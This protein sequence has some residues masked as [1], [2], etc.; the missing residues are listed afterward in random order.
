MFQKKQL[1]V[2]DWFGFHF[3]MI[4]PLVNI[5]IYLILLFTPQ[6]NKTLRNYL[7]YQVLAVFFWIGLFIM[8]I[9][10][11]PNLIDMLRAFSEN[12]PG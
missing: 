12:Y 3:L 10:L 4:I 5:I 9:L 8:L 2:L 7:W 1:G 11:I 6:T